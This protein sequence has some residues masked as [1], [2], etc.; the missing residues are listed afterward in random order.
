MALPHPFELGGEGADGLDRLLWI[1]LLGLALASEVVVT[2][3]RVR[4]P[5]LTDGDGTTPPRRFSGTRRP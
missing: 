3:V 4:Q 1:P 2:G 5:G